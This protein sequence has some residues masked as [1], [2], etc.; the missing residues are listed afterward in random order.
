MHVPS[1]YTLILIGAALL[2]GF[3]FSKEESTP[4]RITRNIGRATP[5][6]YEKNE[7]DPVDPFDIHLLNEIINDHPNICIEFS[8]TIIPSENEDLAARRMKRFKEFIEQHCI[9][10]TCIV[11]SDQIH[12]LPKTVSDQR[13]RIEAAVTSLDSKC[14]TNETTR[15]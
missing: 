3:V 4:V 10:T 1:V 7:L 13:S 8:Q 9:D 15:P 6:L 11:V 12:H 14:A 5:I 2:S